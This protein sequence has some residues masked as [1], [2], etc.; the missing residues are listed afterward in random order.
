MKNLKVNYVITNG[1]GGK[2]GTKCEQVYTLPYAVAKPLTPS[3]SK[4]CES[5]PKGK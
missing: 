5:E 1:G 3:R 2:K 4:D